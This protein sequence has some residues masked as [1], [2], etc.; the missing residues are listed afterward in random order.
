MSARPGWLYPLVVLSL[1]SPA[2]GGAAMPKACLDRDGDVLPAG[3]VDRLGTVRLRH[4]QWV[5]A[6]AFSPLGDLLATSGEYGS[7]GLWRISDGKLLRMLQIKDDW[8][9]AYFLAFSRDGKVLA[10]ARSGSGRISIWDPANGRLRREMDL[11]PLGRMESFAL[12]PDG[13]TV[14]VGFGNRVLGCWD[15]QTGKQIR[16]YPKTM[17]S[18]SLAYSADGKVLMSGDADRNVRVWDAGELRRLGDHPDPGPCDY[19]CVIALSPNG[20]TFAHAIGNRLEIRDAK[21]GA[22]RHELSGHKCKIRALTFS[23]DGK[24]LASADGPNFREAGQPSIRWW[25]ART[26]R[27]LH[28]V[29]DLESYARSVAFSPDGK[30]LAAG[31]YTTAGV[32]SK[33]IQLWD[34]VSGK[35]LL[36]SHGHRSKPWKLVYSSDG[37]LLASAGGDGVILLWDLQA[38]SPPRRLC[39]CRGWVSSLAFSADGRL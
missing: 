17:L 37:R 14:T 31:G 22:S 8:E 28:A 29:T 20:K 2:R 1:L 3:A 30:I 39:G 34:T 15:V 27:L 5:N 7:I 16:Q 18:C 26:G 12:A 19:P 4:G 35:A 38:K 10:C 25:D 21:S 33:T 11:H 13:K 23:A 32:Y 9:W 6:V 36:P 24:M